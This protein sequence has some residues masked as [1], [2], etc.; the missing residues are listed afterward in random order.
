M[1]EK[2]DGELKGKIT[3]GVISM[4][5]AVFIGVAASYIATE[6][7]VALIQRDAK[8]LSRDMEELKKM[9]GV[10]SALQVELASRGSWMVSVDMQLSSNRDGISS[11]S[12]AIKAIA[13]ATSDRLTATQFNIY[14]Q[15]N[16]AELQRIKNKL[17]KLD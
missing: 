5:V 7:N 9:V 2:K 15:N 6:R 4:I 17:D 16:E 12:T 10:V 8:Y 11:N 13:G 14:V 3:S 1:E